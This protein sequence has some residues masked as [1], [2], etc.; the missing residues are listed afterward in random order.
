M[1]FALLLLAALSASADEFD[2]H[3]LAVLDQF[4]RELPASAREGGVFV[5]ATEECTSDPRRHKG[6][7]DLSEDVM[8]A[9]LRRGHDVSRVPEGSRY[10][11]YG[12]PSEHRGK[13]DAPPPDWL[14]LPMYTPGAARRTYCDVRVINSF[15]G[16][17]VVHINGH[18]LS[19][20]GDFL[21]SGDFRVKR[22]DGGMSVE[23][24]E[25]PPGCILPVPPPP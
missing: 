2:A 15:L 7:I 16:A 21:V 25:P 4:L 11:I 18:C 8:T 10:Y 14:Y 20:D 19:R 13:W 1:R 22:V 23:R 3:R 9:L 17:D 24:F 12:H 6:C 5:R